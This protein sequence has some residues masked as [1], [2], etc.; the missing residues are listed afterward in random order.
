MPF[1]AILREV[2][3]TLQCQPGLE[4]LAEQ[5]RPMSEA[6]VTMAG[7]VRDTAPVLAS[8]GCGQAPKPI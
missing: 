2:D 1:E 3:Q 5:H 7:N 8:A 4:G 6:R